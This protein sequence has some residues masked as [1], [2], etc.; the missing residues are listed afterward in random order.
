MGSDSSE[1]LGSGIV[2]G[3]SIFSLSLWF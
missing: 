2:A 1:E 3:L